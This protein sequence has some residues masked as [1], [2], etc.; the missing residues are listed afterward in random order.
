MEK[1]AGKPSRAC[2]DEVCIEEPD[3]GNCEGMD[4][5]GNHGMPTRSDAKRTS[6]IV[7]EN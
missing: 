7:R 6:I 5:I 3:A 2:K 4:G 1:E